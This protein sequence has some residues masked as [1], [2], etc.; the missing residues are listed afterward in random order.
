MYIV[1]IVLRNVETQGATTKVGARKPILPALFNQNNEALFPG[2]VPRVRPGVH[3]P[4]T[5][6]SKCFH[7]IERRLL[8]LAAIFSSVQQ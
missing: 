8:P 6:F 1:S 2:R 3:G 7:S 4:K 5:D